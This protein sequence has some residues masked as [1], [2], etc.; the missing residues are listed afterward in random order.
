VPL[1]QLLVVSCTS[2]TRVPLTSLLET[3]PWMT[4]LESTTDDDTAA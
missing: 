1:G 4:P 3:Q 2:S